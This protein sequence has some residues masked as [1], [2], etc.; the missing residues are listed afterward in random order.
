MKR[1]QES[2]ANIKST[3]AS[4]EGAKGV[5]TQ[6]L[7][8]QFRTNNIRKNMKKYN[9]DFGLGPPVLWSS[10]LLVQGHEHGHSNLRAGQ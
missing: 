8:E 9:M 6:E 4:G 10:G 3:T 7:W 2:A 1:W 5:Q